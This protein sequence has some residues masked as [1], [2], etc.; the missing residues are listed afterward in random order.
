MKQGFAEL[1]QAGSD[2]WPGPL[3][4][5]HC[6]HVHVGPLSAPPCV[7]T[8]EM[9][10]LPVPS[11]RSIDPLVMTLTSPELPRKELPHAFIF[12]LKL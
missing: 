11:A 10:L 7:C 8:S 5:S 1:A 6:W 12:P 3:Q 2:P 9:H 4:H